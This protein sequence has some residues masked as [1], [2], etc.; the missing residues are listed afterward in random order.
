MLTPTSHSIPPP[1]PLATTDLFSMSESL[2]L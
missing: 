1:S 2:F